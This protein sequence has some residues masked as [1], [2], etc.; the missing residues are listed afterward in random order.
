MW[1]LKAAPD[2]EPFL[3]ETIFMKRTRG[4]ECT[5]DNFLINFD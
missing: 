4:L 5:P 1:E 2:D 3:L